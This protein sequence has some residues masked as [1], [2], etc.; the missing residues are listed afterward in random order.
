MENKRRFPRVL[1]AESLSLTVTSAA[2]LVN[3]GERLYCE[4]IDISAAGLQVVLDRFIPAESRVEIWMVLLE[5]RRTYHLHGRI[6]WLEG[7]EIDGKERFNAGI[8]LL[9]VADSDFDA[10]LALFTEE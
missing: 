5:N 8:Q 7:R 3:Q 10:W 9:P 4:S 6:T 2:H 1:K